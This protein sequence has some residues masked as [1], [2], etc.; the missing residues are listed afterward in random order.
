M[1][2]RAASGKAV[3]RG[4]VTQG[5]FFFFFFCNVFFF[6]GNLTELQSSWLGVIAA[7]GLET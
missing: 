3:K 7:A 6:I 1:E 4:A 5:D 2:W